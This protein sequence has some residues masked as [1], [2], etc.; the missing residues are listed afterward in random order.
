MVDIKDC[1]G[2]YFDCD[3]RSIGTDRWLELMGDESY[4]RIGRDELS[5]GT[6][7]STVWL[8]LNQN[9]GR[10]RP[11]VF[12][13]MVFSPAGQPLETERYETLAEAK[14]GHERILR[15]WLVKKAN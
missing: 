5:D 13:T 7:V 2:M 6:F 4:R 3:G 15:E 14:A 10:G 9:Y 11:M 12:E 1:P 8:G